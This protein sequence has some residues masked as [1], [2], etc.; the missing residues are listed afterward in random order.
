MREDAAFERMSCAGCE[1]PCRFTAE[2]NATSGAPN[3]QD[4]PYDNGSLAF[5]VLLRSSGSEGPV[6]IRT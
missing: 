3:G 2:D 6:A 1:E 4:R 5:G